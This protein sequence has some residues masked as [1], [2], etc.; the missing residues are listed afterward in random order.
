MITSYNLNQNRIIYV[1]NT[2]METF[3]VDFLEILKRSLLNFKKIYIEW[4][5]FSSKYQYK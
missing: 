3:D 5:W 2:V 1:S 4:L